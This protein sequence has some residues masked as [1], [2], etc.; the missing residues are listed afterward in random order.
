MSWM[1]LHLVGYRVTV[2]PVEL[3]EEK[4]PGGIRCCW[5]IRPLLTRLFFGIPDAEYFLS[6]FQWTDGFHWTTQIP[7]GSPSDHVTSSQTVCPHVPCPQLH[8]GTPSQHFFS[9]VRILC[10][11]WLTIVLGS[12][13]SGSDFPRP[14]S[15]TWNGGFHQPT[16]QAAGPLVGTRRNLK[17]QFGHIRFEKKIYEYLTAYKEII[18]T[19][20]TGSAPTLNKFLPT[21]ES[22]LLVWNFLARAVYS[23][24]SVNPRRRIDAPLREGIEDVIREVH[25]P[26]SHWMSFA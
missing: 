17:F 9:F 18:L 7:W 11:H 15:S 26:L 25:L 8:S 23:T 2:S 10:H 5:Q 12:S 6:Q 21:D 14:E 19:I 13:H 22:Q 1:K 16:S 4:G 20:R 24:D 3:Q